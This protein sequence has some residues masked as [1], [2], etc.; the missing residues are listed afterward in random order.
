MR[1]CPSVFQ[2]VPN[3]IWEKRERN[4][5][6]ASWS[7]GRGIRSLFW[8]STCVSMGL[9]PHFTTLF[10]LVLECGC[11]IWLWHSLEIFSLFCF[12]S[13]TS[14]SIT[15]R[16]ILLEFRV[17]LWCK[18]EEHF[19]VFNGLVTAF[20][21]LKTPLCLFGWSCG[22]TLQFRLDFCK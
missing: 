3:E 5:G 8:L 12:V 9:A 14:S 1:L 13:V 16:S 20:C 18:A 2:S 4:V 15:I 17:V 11:G 10:H 22:V 19:L 6:L 7:R 21:M